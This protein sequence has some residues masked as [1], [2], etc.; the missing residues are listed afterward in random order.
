MRTNQDKVIGSYR[1]KP[2]IVNKQGFKYYHL[3]NQLSRLSSID[4]HHHL[5]G[6]PKS[7]RNEIQFR[8]H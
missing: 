8:Y 1:Q 5:G 7:A 2:K 4:S 6:I 3:S